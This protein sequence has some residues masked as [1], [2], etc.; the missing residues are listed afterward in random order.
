MQ[1]ISGFGLSISIIASKTFPVGLLLT[2]YADD[3]DPFDS[4]SIQVAD[5]AM[6]LNGDLIIWS[7]PSPLNHTLSVIPKSISDINLGF[8]LNANRVAQGKTGARD[9]VT[10]TVNYPDGTF[11]VLQN[12]A[13]TDGPVATSVASSA[14]YKSKTYGFTFQN[15]IGI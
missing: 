9:V 1:N 3:T 15:I 6:G 8:L 7:K 2:E 14:R 12:G 5:K 10:M 11:V 13:I 4:P